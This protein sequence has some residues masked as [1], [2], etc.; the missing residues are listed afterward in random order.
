MSQGDD[1]IGFKQLHI[2]AFR[3]QD[4]PEQM[5]CAKIVDG[6]AIF[7]VQRFFEEVLC[8]SGGFF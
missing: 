3:V 8:F 5:C 4:L 7:D 1:F 2:E 6:Y